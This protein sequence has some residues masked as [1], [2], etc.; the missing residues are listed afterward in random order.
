MIGYYHADPTD[1]VLLFKN[2]KVA[3]EGAGIAFYYWRPSSSIVSV[4]TSTID[5][6]FILNETSGNFQ[7]VTVQGGRQR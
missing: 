6:P 5:A 3:R 1:Y 2:G 7:T 4:P